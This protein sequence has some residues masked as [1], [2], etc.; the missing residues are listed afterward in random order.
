M[1]ICVSGFATAH[2]GKPSAYRPGAINRKGG[3][4]TIGSGAAKQKED[5]IGEPKAHRYVRRQRRGLGLTEMR[6][7]DPLHRILDVAMSAFPALPRSLLKSVPLPFA[8]AWL[9]ALSLSAILCEFH[10]D[11]NHC[12]QISRPAD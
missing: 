3:Y 4:D 8:R 6:I 7:N 2:S 5:L 11:A 1:G 12:R 9:I 10:L